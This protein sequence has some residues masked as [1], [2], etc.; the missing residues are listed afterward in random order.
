MPKSWGQA[1]W[2]LRKGAPSVLLLKFFRGTKCELTPLQF[3]RH[4]DELFSTLSWVSQS[5][6]GKI[7]DSKGGIVHRFLSDRQFTYLF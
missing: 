6:K 5:K 3:Q 7:N 1:I 2:L 4:F